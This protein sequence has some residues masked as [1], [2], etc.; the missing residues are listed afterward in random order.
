MPALTA[1]NLLAYVLQIAAI[2]AIGAGLPL[3][4]RLTSPRARLIYWRTL[5]IVCLVLPIVQPLVS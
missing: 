2:V 3:I 5:L 1:A 4:L